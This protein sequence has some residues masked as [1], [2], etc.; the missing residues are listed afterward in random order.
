MCYGIMGMADY[1]DFVCKQTLRRVTGWYFK[2][3]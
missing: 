3:R 2:L 1:I